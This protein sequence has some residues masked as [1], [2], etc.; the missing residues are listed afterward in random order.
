M[1]LIIAA[2]HSASVSG[3]VS[4]NLARHLQFGAVAAHHGAQ[5]LVFPELSLT[6]YEPTIARSHAISSDSSCLDPL[7]RLSQEAHM[8]VVV[9]APLL[10][11]AGELH[12]AAFA[13]RS[14]GSVLTYTK[15]HLHP[16]EEQIFTG[17]RCGPMLLVEDAKVAL[18]ICAD[19]A[20]PQ[21][22]ADAA[23]RG[24]NMRPVF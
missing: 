7:R 24:A 6:G 15:E 5:L 2:A 21:H 3:N 22:A 8:T 14:D 20:H 13:I 9:G 17:G 18:A 16:G 19:T 11:A 1:T 23:A 12:I 10:N 4:R